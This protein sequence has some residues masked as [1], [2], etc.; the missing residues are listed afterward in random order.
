[1]DHSRNDFLHLGPEAQHCIG[2][3]LRCNAICVSTAM[4]HCLETGGAHT[5]KPHFTLM[6]ACAELCRTSA[7][8]MLMKA[9]NQ[10]RLCGVCAE[11]CDLCAVDCERI[12]DMPECAEA[13]R[14]CAQACRAMAN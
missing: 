10:D 5:E 12:G 13:C 7:Q 11:I 2:A 3:C 6:I 1:M 9:P 14:D 4:N 8:L